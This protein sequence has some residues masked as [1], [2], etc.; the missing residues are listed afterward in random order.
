SH[1]TR[2][3]CGHRPSVGSAGAAW[4]GVGAVGCVSSMYVGLLG[5]NRTVERTVGDDGAVWSVGDGDAWQRAVGRTAAD[6]GVIGRVVDAAVAR[7]QD[8][9]ISVQLLEDRPT[10][11]GADAAVADQS[12]RPIIRC[13]PSDLDRFVWVFVLAHRE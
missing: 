8:Q 13:D 3:P 9:A 6:R 10:E 7:T 5:T 11:V 1:P 2:L 12:S 4:G